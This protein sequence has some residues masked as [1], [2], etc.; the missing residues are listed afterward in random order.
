MIASFVN[1]NHKTWDQFLK[2]FAYA[3]RTAVHETTGKTPVEIFGHKAYYPVLKPYHGDR[4]RRI[5]ANRDS[6][7]TTVI[8][9]RL[10][11]YELGPYFIKDIIYHPI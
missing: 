7:T 8:R 4:R 6:E 2:E 1:D 10:G 3:L 5:C 9:K 11:D